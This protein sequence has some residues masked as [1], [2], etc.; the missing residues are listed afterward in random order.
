MV[1]GKNTAKLE[2]CAGRKGLPH[3]HGG[4]PTMKKFGTV[5]GVRREV[6]KMRGNASKGKGPGG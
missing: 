1:E 2:K 3:Q 6:R 5:C 4:T